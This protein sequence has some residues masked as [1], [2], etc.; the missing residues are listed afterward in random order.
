MGGLLGLGILLGLG[1]FLAQRPPVPVLWGTYAQGRATSPMALGPDG[2]IYQQGFGFLCAFDSSGKERWTSS[3]EIWV[4]SPPV[5]GQDGTIYVRE[6]TVP[7]AD[8]VSGESH[9]GVLALRP[10]GSVKWRFDVANICDGSE[11][12]TFAVDEQDNIWFRTG[13]DFFSPK[14]LWAVNKD[15][16]EFCH[17]DTT[18]AHYSL[19]GIASDGSAFLQ[20]S[21]RTNTQLLRLKARECGHPPVPVHVRRH[22][23]RNDLSFSMDRNGCVYFPG[24]NGATLTALNPDGSVRWLFKSAFRAYA[25]PTIGPGG[26]LFFTARAGG[27]EI[28]VVAVSGDGQQLWS[29]NIGRHWS[30]I[31]PVVGA[32]GALFVVSGDPK[33]T[34]L[35]ADGS[36]RWVFKPP[37]RLSMAQP[38]NCKD[39]P[40]LWNKN[41]GKGRNVMYSPP[42]LTKDGRLYVYF[43]SPY[44]TLYALKAGVG[45][46][47]NSPWPME[48]G[49]PNQARRVQP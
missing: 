44:D 27:D 43:A 40:R 18:N 38:R 49:A 7:L 28:F 5:V 36:E 24:G 3:K 21:D 35:N 13:K 14:T 19:P 15:G 17:F 23:P 2:T 47:T 34:A 4:D 45:L 8:R 10:D 25:A 33:V 20:G 26:T 12:R 29:A 31:P 22:D 11:G 32:D 37:F 42:V 16:E 6:G 46:A 30:L 1:L 9:S 39:L 48:G 41:F